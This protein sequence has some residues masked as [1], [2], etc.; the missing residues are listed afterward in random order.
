MLEHKL[1]IIRLCSRSYDF[2]L[3]RPDMSLS[4]RTYVPVVFYL[5]RR[6]V[7]RNGDINRNYMSSF[8]PRLHLLV[9]RMRTENPNDLRI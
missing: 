4:A 3:L 9:E 1:Y 6:Y 8:N 7:P 5:C 2:Y